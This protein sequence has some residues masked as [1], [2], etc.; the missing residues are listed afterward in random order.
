MEPLLWHESPVAFS[1]EFLAV[2]PRNSYFLDFLRQRPDPASGSVLL[3]DYSRPR[4]DGAD[5][6]TLWVVPGPPGTFFLAGQSGGPE[7]APLMLRDLDPGAREAV[8]ARYA[9][10]ETAIAGLPAVADGALYAATGKALYRIPL[11]GRD[12]EVERLAAIPVREEGEPLP[13]P[14]NLVVLPDRVLSVADDG[15]LCFGPPR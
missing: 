5:M 15:I 2:A 3:D 10:M 4:R 6:M 7:E 11:G 8:R 9:L 14:G 13:S 12:G 1:G